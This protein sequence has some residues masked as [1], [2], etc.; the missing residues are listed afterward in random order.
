M[1][2][3]RDVQTQR[4]KFHSE[5]DMELFKWR[6]QS[7]YLIKKY[8]R[9]FERVCSNNPK[10]ILDVG[11]G[12]GTVIPYLPNSS[13]V[14]VDL[15]LERLKFA[16]HTFKGFNFASCKACELPFPSDKFDLVF[17]RGLLHHLSSV[18]IP[19]V[20]KEM[21]R[22]CKNGGRVAFIEPNT[23]N[24]SNIFLA[25]VSRAERGIFYCCERNFLKH[26]MKIEDVNKVSVFYD[27]SSGLLSQVTYLFRKC[28]FVYKPWFIRF[29]DGMDRFIK[30]VLLEKLWSEL[31]VI[32]CKSNIPRGVEK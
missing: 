22:V 27:G 11:C 24:F 5:R 18:E 2:S 26:L 6:A 15:M 30:K 16:L 21:I 17:C 12:E 19:N 20:M 29:C 32:I 25:I 31:I 1:Y 10:M 28:A 3:D 14:G 4:F 13:Y 7:P 9:I 8:K 23:I